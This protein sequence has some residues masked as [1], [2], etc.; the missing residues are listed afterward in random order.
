MQKVHLF[1]DALVKL[2]SY[3]PGH[4]GELSH[5]LLGFEQTVV[6]T[7]QVLQQGATHSM[8]LGNLLDMNEPFF[9]HHQLGAAHHEG[10]YRETVVPAVSFNHRL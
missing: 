8:M 3:I 5:L 6:G 1:V 9:I 7:L 4:P 2:L 10:T